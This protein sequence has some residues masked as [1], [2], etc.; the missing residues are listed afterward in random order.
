MGR[1]FCGVTAGVLD[2]ADGTP[3]G[4]MR[5]GVL[6]LRPPWPS[7]F[8][9][10]WRMPD[11]YEAKIRDGWYLTGDRAYVDEDGYFWFVGRDDDV[12]N[13]SGHLV[14]PFEIESAVLEHE[15]VVEA[16]AFPIPDEGAGEAVALKVVLAPGHEESRELIRTL[17]TMVRR[18]VGPYASPR[19]VV[20]VDR[21]PRTRSG[22]IM[23]RVARAEYLGLPLGDTS[24][25]END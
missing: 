14:G 5:E 18:Q 3:L 11:A 24:A 1:P 17:K 19:E 16:A 13:T 7:M 23:R 8:R 22:K 15:A 9:T 6:A 4:P 21:L 12:I 2:A 25:L 10:Y 20:V